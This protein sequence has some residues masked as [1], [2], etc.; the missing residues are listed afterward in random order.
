MKDDMLNTLMQKAKGYTQDEVTTEY[1]VDE[2]GDRRLVKE[3]VVSKYY[4]PDTTALK[5]YIE[6][7]R[8]DEDLDQM[9]DDQLIKEAKKLLKLITKKP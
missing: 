6:L 9:T 1:Q 4:A 5:T 2:N 7:K 8:G 3:K